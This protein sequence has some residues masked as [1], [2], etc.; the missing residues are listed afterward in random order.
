[1]RE[2]IRKHT[3]SFQTA[4]AGIVW[5]FKTQPNF[6]VHLVLALIAVLI[7]LFVGLTAT[8]W[9]LIIFTIFWALSAEMMNTAIEAI[10]DLVTTEWRKEIKIAKDVSAGMMLLVACGAATIGLLVLLPK[11]IS[12]LGLF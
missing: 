3:I 10:A 1:M 2:R 11:L 4:F 6:Q 9:A 8:E 5:A 7:G 12:T